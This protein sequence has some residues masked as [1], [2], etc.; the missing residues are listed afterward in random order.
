[1]INVAINGFGR[2]G[3]LAARIL[4][5]NENYQIVAINDLTNA[6]NLAYLFE[7]DTSYSKL[8]YK[9]SVEDDYLAIKDD[10]KVKSKIKVLNQKD[11]TFLPWKELN[12]DVVLE[13][14]GLFLTRELANSHIKAGSKKVILSA[15]SKDEIPTVVLGV[16]DS[17]LDNKPDI[18]SNASCTTNC[19]SVALKA[20]SHKYIINK[21]FGVTTHAYTATQNLQDSPNKKNNRLS[22]AAG[23]NI[24][25]TSTGADKAV[26]E[27]LPSLIGKFHL[28]SLRVP[29]I[30]G[31]FVY[32][33][34]EVENEVSKDEV[35]QVFK[36]SADQ[37]LKG[38]L[39]YS[40]TDLVSSDI[41][42]NA[43]SCIL[44]SK[45]TEVFG[46]VIKLGLWYDNEWGYA[47]RL[48]E[49]ISKAC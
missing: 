37:E 38:I 18:F 48:V 29:V 30:T 9:V 15:P 31:S 11:P 23:V 41:I 32:L 17:I 8:K 7:Y 12:V 1:M 14:T 49:C 6:E 13:C 43:H 27:V 33:T 47:N 45:L 36:N 42:Q 44:D 28:S 4:L 10:Q 25:P 2:I 46:N 26:E 24:I 21:V 39:E 22:R 3:R 19:V 40:T 35:N 5:E 34:V 20:I 16:N